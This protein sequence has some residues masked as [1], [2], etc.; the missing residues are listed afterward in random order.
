MTPLS[1]QHVPVSFVKTKH[2]EH[3]TLPPPD[4]ARPSVLIETHGCK[5]NQ[6]DSSQ[7]AWEFIEAGYRVVPPGEPAD[8][9]VLN[10]CT[11]TH[12]ADRKGRQA[13]RAARR[14]NPDALIVASGCYA[15]RSAESLRQLDEVDL[16]L[17]NTEKTVLVERV[18]S[19][20]EQI[21]GPYVVGNATEVNIQNSFRTRAMV[22]IQEGCDQI[23]AYCIVPKVR[24]RERSVPQESIIAE[25][26]KYSERGYKEVVLTGTQLGTYGFDLEDTSLSNLLARILQDTDIARLRVSSIQPQE[27]TNGLLDLWVDS[28][29]CPHFHLPLQSG[30]DNILSRMRRRYTADEYANTVVRIRTAISDVSI[31]ADVIVGFPGET[32]EDFSA[33]VALCEA[34]GFSDMHVFPYSKRP[35]TSAAHYGDQIDPPTKSR[36]EHV[37]LG[38]AKRQSRRFRE[39]QVGRI[40]EVLWERQRVIDGCEVWSGLT[41]NYARVLASSRRNLENKITSARLDEIKE[42]LLWAQVLDEAN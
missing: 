33:T 28:R 5:L 17:G 11:V 26:I 7:L 20:R 37:L 32:E 34:I 1:D 19:W 24:G 4:V 40:K 27:M 38:L 2:Q 31:T 25:I 15:Q 14:R 9:Y 18:T 6:A 16:V 41:D 39:S 22:K 42:D 36:R 13:L 29:L 10:S 35:G 23:C 8:V 3:A 30:S 12:I 21:D